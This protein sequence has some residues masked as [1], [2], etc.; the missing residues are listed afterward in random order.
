MNY[1]LSY[2]DF[3]KMED[4]CSKIDDFL[5]YWFIRKALW[6]SKNSIKESASS[7]KKF[8]KCMVSLGY[9]NKDDYNKMCEIIKEN[10]EDWLSNIKDEY[11]I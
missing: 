4:G 11:Y 10:M 6:A 8:Y 7:I 2:Y 9:V 1:F 5:G 3:I